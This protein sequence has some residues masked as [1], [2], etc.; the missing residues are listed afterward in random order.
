M[1]LASFDEATGNGTAA[2]ASYGSNSPK[3]I[4]QYE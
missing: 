4:N 2:R 1:N 3:C